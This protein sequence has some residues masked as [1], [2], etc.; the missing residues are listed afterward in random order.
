MGIGTKRED[1]LH[2]KVKHVDIHQ[3]WV[4]QEVSAGRLNVKWIATKDM[5]ADGLTKALPRQKF[6]TFVKQCGLVD[7]KKEL[8]DLKQHS[9]TKDPHVLFPHQY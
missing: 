1:R 4:R 8:K 2:T 7:I 5:P 6:D 9:N 3:L